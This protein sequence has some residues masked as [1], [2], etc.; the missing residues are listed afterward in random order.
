MGRGF[1]PLTIPSC[2]RSFQ[3]FWG[4]NT[5]PWD[6]VFSLGTPSEVLEKISPRTL[7]RFA[8]SVVLSLTTV[9]SLMADAHLLHRQL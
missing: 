9:M 6:L 7:K 3:A 4:V 8:A 2:S 1:F 5:Y